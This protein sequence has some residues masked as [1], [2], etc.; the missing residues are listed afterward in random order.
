MLVL[1]IGKHKTGSST[2]QQFL[3]ANAEKLRDVGVIY[4]AIG[5][6]KKAHH[7]MAH[8]LEEPSGAS[9]AEWQELIAL[10]RANRDKKVVVSSEAFETLKPKQVK[11]LAKAVGRAEVQ[12]VVYVRELASAL[13]SRYNQLTKKGINLKDF[14]AFYAEYGPTDGYNLRRVIEIWAGNFGWDRMHVRLL[15]PASLVGGTLIDDLLAV[16]GLTLDDLGGPEAVAQSPVNVSMGWK[17]LEVLRSMALEL[18]A[19]IGQDPKQPNRLGRGVFSALRAACERVAEELAMNKDRTQYLSA[20]QHAEC[21]EAWVREVT[22]L[23]AKL[24][25]AKLPL[26]DAGRVVKERPFMPSLEQMPAEER[27]EFAAELEMEFRSKGCGLPEEAVRRLIPLV[28][29]PDDA[30]RKARKARR[31]AWRAERRAARE[32]AVPAVEAA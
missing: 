3:A 27:H 18:T 29:G 13:P 21:Q 19:Q 10:E 24:V 4:P 11:T 8:Q 31:K 7:A 15:D 5:L 1:H 32:A 20:R 26:P 30:L 25:G 9:S 16:L 23:N 28:A 22:A 12:V 14:D 6:G 17:P 2:I